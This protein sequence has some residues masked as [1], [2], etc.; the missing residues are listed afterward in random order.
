MESS[1]TVSKEV[2]EKILDAEKLKNCF[3][4]GICTASCSM[5][6]MLGN[7]YNPRQILED[8]YSNP[9]SVLKSEAIWF[10]AW[11]YRCHNR[12]PQAL[13]LPEI[14]LLMRSAAVKEGNTNVLDRALQKIVK[15][16]PLPLVTTL[17][18]FHPERA[19]LETEK[20]LEKIEHLREESV[21]GRKREK[22]IKSPKER[23]AVIGSGPAGLTTAYELSRKGWRVTV[24]EALSEAGGMLR[25]GIPYYRL[26]KRIIDKEV[27]FIQNLGVDIKTGVRVGK[28]I[29]FDDLKKEGYKAVF[30]GSGAHKSQK[31][32]IEGSDLKG[33]T[34][35]LDFLWEVNAGKKPEVGKNVAVIGG[36]NV[37]VDATRT[38]RC[39]GAS[40]V[41]ILYRRSK[42]EMPANLRE[43]EEVEREGVRIEFLISPKKIIGENG[44]ACALEC[45]HMQLDEPDET[46]KR[47]AIPVEGSD[48][49]RE[50]DMVILAIGEAPNL[51]FLSNEVDLNED[52]TLWTNPLTMETSLPGVFGGG[53]AARGPASVIEAI[54]DGKRAAESIENYLKS[55]KEG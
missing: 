44:K 23:V 55:Q 2:L 18:C 45:V 20:V 17:V 52:G 32:K 8:I 1:A 16:V 47:K 38:A 27:Q 34:Y 28:D 3:E 43:V 31:L 26:P 39:L 53:D 33:V 21:K 14:F 51:E 41:T 5:T 36:G 49:R 4:C 30:I 6:E 50:T 7:E 25:K 37:A 22:G 48:F 29:C 11:C 12:C 9:E 40:E 15:N 35:A 46:G 24:F 19:G 13:D 10:C 42:D 54:R